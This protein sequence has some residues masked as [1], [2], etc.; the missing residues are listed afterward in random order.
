MNDLHQWCNSHDASPNITKVIIKCLKTW[1]AGRSLPSVWSASEGAT[2]ELKN[3]P[4]MLYMVGIVVLVSAIMISSNE[5]RRCFRIKNG[6]RRCYIFSYIKIERIVAKQSY[7]E[8]FAHI[9]IQS[10]LNIF[11]P[12]AYFQIT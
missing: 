3:F 9:N 1:Q 6:S 11:A 8:Q 4:N 5:G 2:A 12:A 10:A 7:I